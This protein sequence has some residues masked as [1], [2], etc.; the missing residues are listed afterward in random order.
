MSNQLIFLFFIFYRNGHF[1]AAQ[2]AISFAIPPVLHAPTPDIPMMNFLQFEV[3]L[4]SYLVMAMQIQY[5]N[6]YKAVSNGFKFLAFQFTMSILERSPI[7][8][9]P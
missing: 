6:I 9:Q 8:L 2:S 3:I 7:F 5:M 4:L 1:T